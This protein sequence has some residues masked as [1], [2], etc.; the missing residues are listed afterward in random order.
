[1]LIAQSNA[2]AQQHLLAEH[3]AASQQQL[4]LRQASAAAAQQHLLLLTQAAAAANAA[5]NQQEAKDAQLLLQATKLGPAP[6]PALVS[7]VD[8]RFSP[9]TTIQPTLGVA[10]TGDEATA[11]RGH[12][13]ID[14]PATRM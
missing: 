5:H 7:N 2:A 11:W 9:T 1:M 13:F 4:L 8:P 10:L 14:K 12:Y 6:P 3:A